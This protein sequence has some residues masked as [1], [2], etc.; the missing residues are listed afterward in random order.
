MAKATLLPR[1]WAAQVEQGPVTGCWAA[2]QKD[3]KYM[4]CD[5]KPFQRQQ[6]ERAGHKILG[7]PESSFRFYLETVWKNSNELLGQPSISCFC[8]FV[9]KMEAITLKHYYG[10]SRCFC[11][12]SSVQVS[13]VAQSCPTLCDPMNHRMPGLPVHH[14]LPEFTQTHVH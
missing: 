10:Y 13:S 14:Q 7:W 8:S 3:K 11:P 12:F 1:I 4:H 9:R 2:L 6:V 5:R